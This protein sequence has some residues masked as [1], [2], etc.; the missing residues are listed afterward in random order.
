LMDQGL[1]KEGTCVIIAQ[2]Q[3]NSRHP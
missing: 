2:V 1:D 3:N